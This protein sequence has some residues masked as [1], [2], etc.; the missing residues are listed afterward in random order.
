MASA[1]PTRGLAKAALCLEARVL[2]CVRMAP[3]AGAVYLHLV[4][5]RAGAGPVA[6]AVAFA[7]TSRAS[8][9]RS[10]SRASSSGAGQ[11]CP[12]P[13]VNTAAKRQERSF[14]GPG[15]AH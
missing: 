5:H 9:S 3:R 11:L 13:G 8:D 6:L 4:W 1:Y 14:S 10:Q 15:S 2:A 7:G 12:G